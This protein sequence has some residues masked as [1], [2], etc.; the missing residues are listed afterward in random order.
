ME[1]RQVESLS[2]LDAVWVDAP[3]TGSGLLRR[4]P[5]IRWIKDE[6]TLSS[7]QGDQARLL[8]EA[9]KKV[10]VGGLL[11]FTVCS[12]LRSDELLVALRTAALDHFEVVREWSLVPQEEPFG[13]GFSGILMVREK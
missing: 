1:R 7:L 4:H 8:S 3:C 9:A 13:D 5:E 10:R 2:E 6:K 11:M 12:V